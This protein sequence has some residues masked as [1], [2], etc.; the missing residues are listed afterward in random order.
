M[1]ML[2]NLRTGRHIMLRPVACVRPA[3]FGL[4]TVV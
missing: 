3:P 4:Q 1:A 2:C